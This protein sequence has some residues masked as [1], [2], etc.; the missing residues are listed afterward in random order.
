M[1]IKLLRC[2]EPTA[3]GHIYPTEV[4]ERAIEDYQEQMKKAGGFLYGDLNANE[5]GINLAEVSHKITDIYLEDG[6]VFVEVEVLDTPFGQH[7]SGMC[8]DLHITPVGVGTLDKDGCI[9][10]YVIAKTSFVRD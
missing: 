9:G 10:D 4:V 1:K 7:L 5:V 2:D 8:D 6:E 3:A